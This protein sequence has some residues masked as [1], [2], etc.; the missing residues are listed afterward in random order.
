MSELS[1]SISRI[2]I[3]NPV[4]WHYEC[5]ESAIHYLPQ[6]LGSRYGHEIQPNLANISLILAIVPEPG[7]NKY[8]T[9]YREKIMNKYGFADIIINP[10]QNIGYHEMPNITSIIRSITTGETQ[11]T[12]IHVFITIPGNEFSNQEIFKIPN[13]YYI[14][15][16]YRSNILTPSN[17]FYLAPHC[18]E[19]L[20]N[21]YFIPDVLPFSQKSVSYADR[22]QQVPI[23]EGAWI[24]IQGSL[25]RRRPDLVKLLIKFTLA[26]QKN[27]D[28]KPPI[29]IIILT[30]TTNFKI[31]GINNIHL[32]TNSDFWDFHLAAAKC[33]IIA[34]LVSPQSHNHYYTSKLTSS[35]SYGMAYRMRFL[36]DT[37]LYQ[38]FIPAENYE[39]QKYFT[40]TTRPDFIQALKQV[41]QP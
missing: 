24:L 13:T 4:N 30:K 34:T 23:S 27:T 16:N 31:E 6:I 21:N 3:H 1:H 12:D 33:N 10:V 28:N 39:H 2:I 35:I 11:D 29:N 5:I 7:F 19:K 17:V 14:F 9:T 36:I 15:H 20:P 8:I 18:R 26:N 22:P 37:K 40:Y 25:I 38:I 41:C 32:K